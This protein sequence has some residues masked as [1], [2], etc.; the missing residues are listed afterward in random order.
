MTTVVQ[1]HVR[2][3]LQTPPRPTQTLTGWGDL[4]QGTRPVSWITATMTWA[5]TTQVMLQLRN[6]VEFTLSRCQD[7]GQWN[8]EDPVKCQ[9]PINKDN[10]SGINLKYGSINY[11]NQLKRQSTAFA[12]LSAYAHWLQ[13]HRQTPWQ[14]LLFLEHLECLCNCSIPVEIN[15]DFLLNFQRIPWILA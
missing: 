6:S 11:K 5:R 9:M 1:I 14:I 10:N 8:P 4:F 2:T 13:T 15:R 3:L 12:R 7:R